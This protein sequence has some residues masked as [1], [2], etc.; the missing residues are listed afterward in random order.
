[1]GVS[2]SGSRLAGVAQAFAGREYRAY[3]AGNFISLTGTW[4]QRVAVGWVAWELTR[5]GTW[6][7]LVAV[8]DLLP[9]VILGPLAGALADRHD[10]LAIIRA[11]QLVSI[12]QS[13]LLA[14]LTWRGWIEPESLLVLTLALGI[15]NAINQPARLA[16]VPSL[17]ERKSLASAV[18]INA[19]SFNLARFIGPVVAGTV[20]VGAGA[21]TAF[22]LNAASFAV[23]L[24]ALTQLEKG[25][26][27]PEPGA[28]PRSLVRAVADGWKYAG[29]H[30]VIGGALILIA[31]LSLLSRGSVE[32]LPGF[33]DVVF[34]RGAEGFAWLT[35]MIG[36]GAVIGGA[37]MLAPMPLE[38]ISRHVRTQVLVVSVVLLAFTATANYWVA[39]PCL[40]LAGFSMVVTGIG[41]QTIV[42]STV[43]PAMRGRVMSI[44]GMI[45]RGVPAFGALAMGA[46]SE[47]TGLRLPVAVGAALCFV[48]WLWA[49]RRPA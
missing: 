45:I 4:V 19:I 13:G 1:M 42:Q 16:L 9:T 34:G 49:R 10:K 37:W 24:L 8:A 20:I 44:Y 35:A 30:A 25:R 41:T 39:L 38:R 32:L 6:L 40:F 7:G 36:L 15:I 33:A 17:V 21:A 27:R 47:V 28:E 48:L 14:L 46:A 31:V 23:M 2:A 43:E 11:S 18:A 3:A 26:G 29:N 12:V 5:S 22:A